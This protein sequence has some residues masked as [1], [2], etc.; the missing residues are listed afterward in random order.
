MA[1]TTTKKTSKKESSGTK[2]PQRS[3]AERD[4]MLAV[5]EAILPETPSVD[6]NLLEIA[7]KAF[8]DATESSLCF[9]IDRIETAADFVTKHIG[10]TAERKLKINSAGGGEPRLVWHGRGSTA[11]AVLADLME[12]VLENSQHYIDQVEAD[13]F[14]AM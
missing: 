1:K 3:R 13:E 6:P 10:A 4:A 12:F 14:V 2:K 9:M 5:L 7:K 8:P 11:N